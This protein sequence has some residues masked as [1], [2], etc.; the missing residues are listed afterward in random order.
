MG[1]IR[2]VAG[3]ALA[4]PLGAAAAERKKNGKKRS[5]DSAGDRGLGPPDPGDDSSSDAG[6]DGGFGSYVKRAGQGM[7]RNFLSD[8]K[9]Q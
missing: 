6:T 8:R 3:A 4:G 5:G 2:D 7:A 9:R 1:L